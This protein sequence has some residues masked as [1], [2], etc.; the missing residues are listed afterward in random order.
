MGS[1]VF[2]GFNCT[3]Q[4]VMPPLKSST[5]PYPTR[6]RHEVRAED[7][8]CLFPAV[9]LGCCC[10]ARTDTAAVGFI[11]DCDPAQAGGDGDGSVLQLRG[12]ALSQ[13]SL[14]L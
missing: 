6:C 11:R 13:A 7:S 5:V 4:G 2:S 9:L 3:L 1:G 8:T 10:P 14:S 12:A